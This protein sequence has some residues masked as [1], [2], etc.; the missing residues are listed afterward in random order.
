MNITDCPH[1]PGTDEWKAWQR[2]AL[3]AEAE[4]RGT[5]AAAGRR[6]DEGGYGATDDEKTAAGVTPGT[7]KWSG[8]QPLDA[9]AEPW[10][11]RVIK[12]LETPPPPRQPLQDLDCPWCR[13]RYKRRHSFEAHVPKCPSPRHIHA[14]MYENGDYVPRVAS[15]PWRI[16]GYDATRAAQERWAA[17]EEERRRKVAELI[18][19]FGDDIVQSL[20]IKLGS[21]KYPDTAAALRVLLLVEEH[22][23]HPPAR[24]GNTCRPSS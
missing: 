24:E 11:A 14:P 13:R 19:R 10:R 17:E 15:R 8:D 22:G 2:A 18:A 5:A 4:R 23:W 16:V 9:I 21:K 1:R 6:H 3:T 7:S 20:A 12:A